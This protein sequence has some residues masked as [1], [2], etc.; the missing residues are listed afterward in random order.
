MKECR[1]RNGN[2]STLCHFMNSRRRICSQEKVHPRQ[3]RID[4]GHV[5]F[6]GRLDMLMLPFYRIE[7]MKI[8]FQHIHLH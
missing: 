2:A 5:P 1:V 7:K 8:W 4:P 6:L 3:F